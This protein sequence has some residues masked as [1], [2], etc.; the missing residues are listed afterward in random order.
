[1][2]YVWLVVGTFAIS[3]GIYKSAT[4]GFLHDNN[5]LLFIVAAV[6]F[7]MYIFR[8][9]RRIF[10]EEQAKKEEDE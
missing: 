5:Y 8:R 1:M 6:S 3:F 4:A 10:M 2:E 9:K 7:S